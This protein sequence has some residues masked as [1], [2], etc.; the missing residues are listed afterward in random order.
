[1]TSLTTPDNLVIWTVSDPDALSTASAAMQN[2]VQAALSVRQIKNYKWPNS[3]ARTAQTGMT[4]GDTGYQSDTKILY[5]YDGTAWVSPNSGW[6]TPTLQNGWINFGGAYR[7]CQY[8]KLNGVV[9]ITGLIKGGTTAAS[10]VLFNLPAGYR[11]GGDL[12]MGT[13]S[14]GVLATINISVGGNVSLSANVSAS[15]LTL[16]FSFIA[17]A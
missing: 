16:Q 4:A 8:I 11:P 14:G 2:S 10:T 17:E 7:T 9:Y 15:S 13:Q 12:F 3:A 6:I 5:T 1:M